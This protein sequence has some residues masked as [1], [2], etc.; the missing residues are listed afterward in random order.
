MPRDMVIVLLGGDAA[1]D[2][3]GCCSLSVTTAPEPISEGFR[4]RSNPRVPPKVSLARRPAPAPRTASFSGPASLTVRH[5]LVWR[6]R[7]LLHICLANNDDLHREGGRRPREFQTVSRGGRSQ[8]S[9]QANSRSFYEPNKI[10]MPPLVGAA[11]S[12]SFHARGKF[13]RRRHTERARASTTLRR[14]AP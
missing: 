9:A 10:S 1:A 11:V 12:L 6:K 4:A 7:A 5:E 13:P 14:S 3:E 8:R 2:A